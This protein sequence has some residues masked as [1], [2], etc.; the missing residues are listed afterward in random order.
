MVRWKLHLALR[1]KPTK[2]KAKLLSLTILIPF[3][4]ILTIIVAVIFFGVF[5]PTEV[6]FAA[7]PYDFAKSMRMNGLK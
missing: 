5:T 1:G 6:A 4:F 2:W 3:S 7:W